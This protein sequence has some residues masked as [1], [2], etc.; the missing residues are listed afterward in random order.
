MPDET[1]NIQVALVLDW[2]LDKVD[3][4]EH[5]AIIKELD[6]IAKALRKRYPERKVRMINV[7]IS[8]D[9]EDPLKLYCKVD[10]EVQ[11]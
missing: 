10:G 5:E 8:S 7:L 9:P 6:V 2:D 3:Q 4:V 11:R 1:I